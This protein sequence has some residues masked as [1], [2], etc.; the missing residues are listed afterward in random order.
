VATVHVLV[1]VV[2]LY[3]DAEVELVVSAA[4]I[5]MVETEVECQIVTVIH[6]LITS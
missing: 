5:I 6:I 3:P 4:T 1:V 2:I